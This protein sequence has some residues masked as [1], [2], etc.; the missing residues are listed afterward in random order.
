MKKIVVLVL[1]LGIVGCGGVNQTL[2][3]R[4]NGHLGKP[5]SNGQKNADTGTRS[6]KEKRETIELKQTKTSSI[7]WSSQSIASR[8]AASEAR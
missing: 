8:K 1:I 3:I 4:T 2:P 7:D 6:E 5:T